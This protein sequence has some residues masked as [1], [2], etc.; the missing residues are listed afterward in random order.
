MNKFDI[1]KSFENYDNV[2]RLTIDSPTMSSKS[3]YHQIELGQRISRDRDEFY[4]SV[5]QNLNPN[6]IALRP[7]YLDKVTMSAYIH[8]LKMK[9][10]VMEDILKRRTEEFDR[11]QEELIERYKVQ[12]KLKFPESGLEVEEGR[13]S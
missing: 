7:Q 1:S 13:I 12:K 6:D 10:L 11:S 8:R 9:Q 5:D 3:I 4:D 2:D